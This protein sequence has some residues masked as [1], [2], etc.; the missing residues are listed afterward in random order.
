MILSGGL[1]IAPILPLKSH[2]V[3]NAEFPKNSYFVISPLVKQV[4]GRQFHVG[5]SA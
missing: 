5:V 2:V 4:V 1:H 3:R